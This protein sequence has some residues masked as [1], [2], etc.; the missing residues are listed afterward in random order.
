M[1]K[2]L[3]VQSTGIN[4]ENDIVDFV[5]K[6]LQ[7][8]YEEMIKCINRIVMAAGEEE[9]CDPHCVS[10]TDVGGTYA[11]PKNYFGI[12]TVQNATY[13]NQVH[14][15]PNH[16]CYLRPGTQGI[17][18]D[19]TIANINS[20]GMSQWASHTETTIFDMCINDIISYLLKGMVVRKYIP[21]VLTDPLYKLFK[22]ITTYMQDSTFELE[23]IWCG[24]KE[25]Y[26]LNK[27]AN[28]WGMSVYIQVA[29]CESSV[30][31]KISSI[32]KGFALP[33]NVYFTSSNMDVVLGTL[34]NVVV[35]WA[36][37]FARVNDTPTLIFSKHLNQKSCNHKISVSTNTPAYI[38]LNI[39]S[40][41]Q[42]LVKSG[43]NFEFETYSYDKSNIPVSIDVNKKNYLLS[44][45]GMRELR[46]I[47]VLVMENHD[48]CNG[49]QKGH[50]YIIRIDNVS[51]DM[52]IVVRGAAIP[53]VFN[54]DF[55]LNVDGVYPR[56]DVIDV[57]SCDYIA[58]SL[59]FGFA[60]QTHLFKKDK[61]KTYCLPMMSYDDEIISDSYLCADAEITETPMGF[62]ENSF[63]VMTFKIPRHMVYAKHALIRTVFDLGA[64]YTSGPNAI[65][66]VSNNFAIQWEICLDGLSSMI[67]SVFENV[68]VV[69]SEWIPT[70]PKIIATNQ[71]LL[72]K[73]DEYPHF[74]LLNDGVS[75]YTLTNNESFVGDIPVGIPENSI[76][77]V[78]QKFTVDGYQHMV[79]LESPLR[80]AVLSIPV[81]LFIPNAD[82]YQIGDEV[83]LS[84]LMI[85]S[86]VLVGF[87]LDCRAVGTF[88]EHPTT[89]NTVAWVTYMEVRRPF[90]DGYIDIPVVFVD[91]DTIVIN[92]PEYDFKVSIDVT[93]DS[94]QNIDTGESGSEEESTDENTD[95][96]SSPTIGGS[97]ETVIEEEG[98]L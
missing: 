1:K 77:S 34:S 71:V 32:L 81:G 53:T 69:G 68:G 56:V 25:N 67:S 82:K 65:Q 94:H 17:V 47:G 91:N 15:S 38:G 96:S 87:N 55:K 88:T 9:H 26:N 72:S 80:F 60:G 57:P 27:S 49:C 44:T 95:N 33:F 43:D 22:V 7:S 45:Y 31:S 90:I 14:V 8:Y 52:D 93:I 61:V 73:V 21:A 41:V 89:D 58:I 2:L 85:Q 74:T 59:R 20:S 10:I 16:K 86:N 78:V 36:F 13:A 5:P 12:H 62:G 29:N 70:V 28:G 30:I 98:E 76:Y 83:T 92:I 75:S 64:F 37:G 46:D 51:S 63:Y 3:V 19:G 50:S 84:K 66:F 35:P 42:L 40:N 11:I 79:S 39:P 97:T 6:H 48:V 23:G 54:S 24:Q 18:S 4:P